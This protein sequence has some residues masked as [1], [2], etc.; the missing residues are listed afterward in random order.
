MAYFELALERLLLY[1]NNI[2]RVL[3]FTL[4]ALSNDVWRYYICT[5]HSDAGFVYGGK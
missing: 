2:E 1:E 5:F 4:V 3:F